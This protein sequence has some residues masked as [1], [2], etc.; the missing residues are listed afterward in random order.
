MATRVIYAEIWSYNFNMEPL[1]YLQSD[2]SEM[3]SYWSGLGRYYTESAIGEI[4]INGRPFQFKINM[5]ET[6]DNKDI[7]AKERVFTEMAPDIN[8]ESDH[9][10]IYMPGFSES[11]AQTEGDFASVLF[12]VLTKKG[13]KNPRLLGLN[14]CGKGTREY[15]ENADSISR[16]GLMNEIR[17]VRDLIWALLQ[18]GKI[19]GDVSVISHSMGF[20][21]AIG[22][23]DMFRGLKKRPTFIG[24]MPCTDRS[25]GL[26]LSP[27]FLWTTRK[28]VGIALSQT[29][30]RKGGVQVSEA[31]HGRMMFSANNSDGT[32]TFHDHWEASVPD[33]AYRFVGMTLNTRRLLNSIV[34]SDVGE[35][36]KAYVMRAQR[37]AVIPVSM[38]SR[39]IGRLKGLGMEVQAHPFIAKSFPHAIPM[40][41]TKDQI[42]EL[43]RFFEA[44]Y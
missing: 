10:A 15:V 23:W 40:D 1:N 4:V 30:R 37:D 26:A 38:V 14:A 35:G 17:D 21:N 41:M 18:K 34:K 28:H 33:S 22:S 11:S 24:L 7:P 5:N 36:S 8:E 39:E 13:Y 44:V 29:I 43:T 3:R 19:Q 2:F 20:L 31:D 16:I 25:L 6:G 27:K 9:T 42:M 32:D 12:E